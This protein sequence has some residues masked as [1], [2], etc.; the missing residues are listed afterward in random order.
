M[1]IGIYV[2]MYYVCMYVCSTYIYVY[3]Y[4]YIFIGILYTYITYK[5][6]I[7][8]SSFLLQFYWKYSAWQMFR[9]AKKETAMNGQ[10]LL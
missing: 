2:C 3:I 5:Y 10:I 4:I 6:K 9:P 1:Y 8:I 7:V